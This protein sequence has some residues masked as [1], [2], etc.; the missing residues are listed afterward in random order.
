MHF[1]E[2]PG[3]IPNRQVLFFYDNSFILIEPLIR[4]NIVLCFLNLFDHILSLFFM[5]NTIIVVIG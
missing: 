2:L 5:I 3:E 4:E 1:M